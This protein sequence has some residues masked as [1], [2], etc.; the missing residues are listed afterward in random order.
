MKHSRKLLF[1][2]SAL[3][4]ILTLAACQTKDSDEDFD[5]SYD[6]DY[7]MTDYVDQLVRDGATTVTGTIEIT[8]EGNQ[9]TLALDEKKVIANDNY[10]DGYYIADTNISNTYALENDLSFVVLEDGEPVM[11]TAEEFMKNHSGDTDSLYTVY[12]MGD[13][14]EHI[15]PLD[16]KALP[17]GDN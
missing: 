8:G 11:C 9:Y 3:F 17:A 14:V 6:V 13:V 5:G 15:M 1:I 2:I 7:L 4:I 16:P 12:L 10:E